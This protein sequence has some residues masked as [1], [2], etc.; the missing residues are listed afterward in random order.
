MFSQSSR[1]S[2][3]RDPMRVAAQ[4]RDPSLLSAFPLPVPL[5]IRP[6]HLFDRSFPYLRE[7][8]VAFVPLRASLNAKRTYVEAT[9]KR[10]T[11]WRATQTL[12]S[13]V[14]PFPWPAFFRT[15]FMRNIWCAT[16]H[17][18]RTE[19][20]ATRC[21]QT[22]VSPATRHSSRGSRAHLFA[23]RMHS[24]ITSL[25]INFAI[26]ASNILLIWLPNLTRPWP[27]I[28]SVA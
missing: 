20:R 9:A 7:L 26:S 15:V 28:P 10:L 6:R 2:D 11:E 22:K 13:S 12:G 24:E 14:C 4:P 18:C 8:Q 17:S 5:V 1:A 19:F 3:V 23:P 25:R 21:K 16:R 27:V